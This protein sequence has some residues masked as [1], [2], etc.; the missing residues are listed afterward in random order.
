MI[1]PDSSVWISFLHGYRPPAVQR[2]IDVDPLEVAV[3]DIVLLEILQG[4]R[5]EKF[6][7]DIESR[8]RTFAVVEMLGENV[9]VAAA[10]NYRELRRLGITPKRTPD[11]IIATFCIEGR[12]RLLHQDGDYEHFE[13]HLGLKV[14]Y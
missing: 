10:R 13:R 9:A 5:S 12:H 11:L 1:I 14:L 3:G 6:A 7:Q 2:L 8:L 4:A